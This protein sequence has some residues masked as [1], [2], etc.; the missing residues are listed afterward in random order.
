[1]SLVPL[2][3]LHAILWT[4]SP[5]VPLAAAP[6]VFGLLIIFLAGLSIYALSRRLLGSGRAAVWT[7]ILYVICVQFV[8][9]LAHLEHQSTAACMVFSPLI[10]LGL[11]VSASKGVSHEWH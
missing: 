4:V 6:K 1:M 3:V 11:S 7:A 10:L 9:R 2:G 5:F 8:L